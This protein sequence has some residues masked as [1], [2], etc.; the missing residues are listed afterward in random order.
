MKRI[1][2][3]KLTNHEFDRSSELIIELAKAL[4]TEMRVANPDW[5]EA[6]VRMQ[7]GAGYFEVK[8]SYVLPTGPK[9]LNIL[10]HKPFIARLQ[11]IGIKLQDTLPQS[12]VPF[13]V[14]ILRVGADMNYEMQYEYEDER[15][16]GIS[17]L[18]GGSGLPD[19]YTR[20]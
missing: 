6:F 16:C 17:K 19:G 4:V 18:N 12:T 1:K 3:E 5:Q 13:C 11:Q 7:A 15:R 10:D 14:A 9:I 8:C 20:A 2:R